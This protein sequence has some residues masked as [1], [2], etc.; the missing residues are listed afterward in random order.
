MAQT[1]ADLLLRR[2]HLGLFHPELLTEPLGAR[3]VSEGASGP[4]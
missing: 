4:R 3:S 2:T 1:P